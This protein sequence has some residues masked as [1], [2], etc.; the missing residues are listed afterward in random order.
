MKDR[1]SGNTINKYTTGVACKPWRDSLNPHD[2]YVPLIVAYPGRNKKELT[3]IVDDIDY[4]D[5]T[6]GCYG[7]W[8]VTDF[9]K[10][11]IEICTI[12]IP[13]VDDNSKNILLTESTIVV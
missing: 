5:V 8:Y 10:T 12:V 1:A 4:C 13:V 3:D 2:S 11:I 9:I 6:K 7:N